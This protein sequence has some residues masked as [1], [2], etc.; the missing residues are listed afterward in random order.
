MHELSIATALLDLVGRHAP[1][2]VTVRAVQVRIGPL[3]A[4][5]PE[6]MRFAWQ[7][8]TRNTEYDNTSLELDLLPWKLQCPECGRKFECTTADGACT[9]G[10]M[11]AVPIEGDD[12]T[13]VSLDVEEPVTQATVLETTP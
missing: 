10:S 5:E 4:I 6:A 8:A 3:Q 2:G 12:L 7:A 13:L 11:T 9:C 1:A